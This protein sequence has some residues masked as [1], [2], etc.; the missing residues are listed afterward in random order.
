MIITSDVAEM[1]TLNPEEQA[2]HETT[3]SSIAE[4][5]LGWISFKCSYQI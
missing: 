5:P 1:A 4:I 3:V 2:S